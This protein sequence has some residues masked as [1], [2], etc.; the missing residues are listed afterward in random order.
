MTHCDQSGAVCSSLSRQYDMRLEISST[1]SVH[2]HPHLGLCNT[3]RERDH[4]IGFTSM[5]GDFYIELRQRQN[6]D[7]NYM[8]T[9]VDH[10]NSDYGR[11]PDRLKEGVILGFQPMLIDGAVGSVEIMNLYGSEKDEDGSVTPRMIN[12]RGRWEKNDLIHILEVT[13]RFAQDQ[14]EKFAPL[15][16]SILATVKSSNTSD[17]AK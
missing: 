6:S 3:V 10:A 15:V 9:A 12:W 5:S 4:T 8:Q 13:A 16:S 14:Q 1:C 11:S 7:S 17:P 2:I